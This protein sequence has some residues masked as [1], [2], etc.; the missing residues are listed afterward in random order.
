MRR[1]IALTSFSVLALMVAGSAALACE[2][3]SWIKPYPSSGGPGTPV[4]VSGSGFQPGTVVIRWDASAESGGAELARG[5]VDAEG[6]I[7]VEVVVP[8]DAAGQHKFVAE[9]TESTEQVA[10]ADAWD[11]FTIPG[12][13]AGEE[14][15]AGSEHDQ[16][17]ETS[18]GATKA[19]VPSTPRSLSDPATSEIPETT[20]YSAEATGA[21]LVSQPVDKTFSRPA[22]EPKAADAV[23]A[24]D[25]GV[26]GAIYVASS[27]TDLDLVAVDERAGDGLVR[28]AALLLGVV[29]IVAAWLMKRSRRPLPGPVFEVVAEQPMN[30][31]VLDREAA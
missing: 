4:T 28:G 29:M 14:Q 5:E 6:N 3:S 9:H 25:P 11:Y 1:V 12:A 16:A 22:T 21:Q 26:G 31:D 13:V 23:P 30:D 27:P 17:N 18:N 24:L 20:S 7:S 15:G 10:H 19:D 2:T 8:E